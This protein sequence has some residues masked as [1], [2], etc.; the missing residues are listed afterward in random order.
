ME[1]TISD[2]GMSRWTTLSLRGSSSPSKDEEPAACVS[3]SSM[4]DSRVIPGK[5]IPLSRP[6]VTNS[7]SARC[8]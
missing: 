7:R 1:E 8:Q 2:I 3:R 6:I 4:S 5:T